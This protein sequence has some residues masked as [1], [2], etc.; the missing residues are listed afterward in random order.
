MIG[1]KRFPSLGS[2]GRCMYAATVQCPFLLR[3]PKVTVDWEALTEMSFICFKSVFNN[4]FL[5][6]RSASCCH[7]VLLEVRSRPFP[8]H[9]QHSMFL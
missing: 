9:L 5:N 1:I 3:F 6:P 4:Q 8:D 2:L 7:V